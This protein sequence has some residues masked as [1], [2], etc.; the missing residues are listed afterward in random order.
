LQIRLE[1]DGAVARYIKSLKHGE[2]PTEVGLNDAK[3]PVFF[4]PFAT[5]I[6]H[7]ATQLLR[8]DIGSRD[9]WSFSAHM[10][11]DSHLFWESIHWKKLPDGANAVHEILRLRD[12]KNGWLSLWEHKTDN[13]PKDFAIE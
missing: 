7:T 1:D 3:H 12:P 13:F 9:S 5:M 11:T 4:G 10:Q 2:Q 8:L 6:P